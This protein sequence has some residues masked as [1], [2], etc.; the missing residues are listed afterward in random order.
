MNPTNP[1][2]P[3]ASAAAK[4]VM[5]VAFCAAWHF[6]NSER[7]RNNNMPRI[8]LYEVI[9]Q[10]AP[11]DPKYVVAVRQGNSGG[12]IKVHNELGVVAP[13]AENVREWLAISGS[14]P[15]IICPDTD[16]PG[17][18]SHIGQP[19]AKTIQ[20]HPNLN[21]FLVSVGMMNAV[22]GYKSPG[23]PNKKNIPPHLMIRFALRDTLQFNSID[24]FA[25]VAELATR[26][27]FGA[28]FAK[29]FWPLPDAHIV[30][31]YTRNQKGEVAA[32]HL[33]A[34]KRMTDKEALN[35]AMCAMANEARNANLIGGKFS[36]RPLITITCVKGES[37]GI[38]ARKVINIDGL[39]S[40]HLHRAW[41]ENIPADHP[42]RVVPKPPSRR[43]GKFDA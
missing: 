35:T 17:D 18:A 13:D 40:E 3:P 23:R 26:R 14:G 4:V 41:M 7:Q 28:S 11:G 6:G 24:R 9:E 21:K 33:N 32:S 2:N 20:E 34:D 8:A 12:G 10:D 38:C 31:A 43:P 16:K 42:D 22:L 25:P 37:G 19:D 29:N 5:T 39:V 15:M 36:P 1:S 27:H 30:V